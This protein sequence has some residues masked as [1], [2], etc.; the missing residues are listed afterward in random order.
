MAPRL[1]SYP[2]AVG[3]YVDGARG[4]YM[5]DSIVSL[6]EAFGFEAKDCDDDECA[7]CANGQHEA[8]DGS[9]TEWSFCQHDNEIIEEANE[10]LNENH[11]VEGCYWG[12]IDTGDW[13]LWPDD[14]EEGQSCDSRC[15][16]YP[17]KPC[18]IHEGGQS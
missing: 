14:D 17:M 6:A 15:R 2:P 4:I 9:Y 3:C 18:P 10:Y 12:H 5:V 16:E 7:R 8:G 1:T 13:G 11:A